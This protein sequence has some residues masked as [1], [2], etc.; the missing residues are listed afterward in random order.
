M[1]IKHFFG[2]L[3]SINRSN[4][5]GIVM[6][7]TNHCL[8]V[9]ERNIIYSLPNAEQSKMYLLFQC[10]LSFNWCFSSLC[11][12]FK[13]PSF[14]YWQ[15]RRFCCFNSHLLI[16]V[17]LDNKPPSSIEFLTQNV[18]RS[19]SQSPSWALNTQYGQWF[20]INHF[21]KYYHCS[22]LKYFIQYPEGFLLSL[23]ELHVIVIFVAF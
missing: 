1:L 7:G 10:L 4:K 18:F 16:H 23:Q 9:P 20:I 13:N 11:Y 19:R 15:T 6:M 12:F 17:Q 3:P 14:C 8:G 21:Y 22:L 2:I 5:Q